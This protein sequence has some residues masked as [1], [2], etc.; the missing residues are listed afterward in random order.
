MTKKK[1]SKNNSTDVSQF[2]DLMTQASEMLACDSKCQ[3]ERKK[4]ELEDKYLESKTNLLTAPSQVESSYKN[5]LTFTKGE[6]AYS[7]Y[8]EKQLQE[9]AKKM[10][11]KMLFNFNDGRE[12]VNIVLGTYAGLLANYSHVAEYYERL[13]R[14]NGLLRGRLKTASADVATN[15]RKTFYE[16]QKIDSV[17]YYYKVCLLFYIIALVGVVLLIV[18]NSGIPWGKKVVLIL[19]FSLYPFFINII[20][21]YVYRVYD[22]VVSLLPKNV[23]KTI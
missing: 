1:H 8:Q 7:E 16:D 15:D 17:Y 10:G 23:Y 5:Y 21:Y 4:K 19:F 22:I 14:E 2:N 20:F 11:D 6:A 12:K 9:K 13:K 18:T 3:E